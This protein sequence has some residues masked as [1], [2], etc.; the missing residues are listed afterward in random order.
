MK[1]SNLCDLFFQELKKY[2]ATNFKTLLEADL[3]Q[4][5]PVVHKACSSVVTRYFI[6]IEKH[7]ELSDSEAKLLYFKLKIDLIARYFSEYPVSSTSD[8]VPFQEEMRRYVQRTKEE[9]NYGEFNT[10]V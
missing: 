10:A 9:M 2:N 1:G 6:F 7:P 5:N 4:D 8:L 3:Q